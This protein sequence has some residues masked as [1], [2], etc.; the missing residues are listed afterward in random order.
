MDSHLA[1]L[2][3]ELTGVTGLTVPQVL[4]AFIVLCSLLLYILAANLAWHYRIAPTTRISRGINRLTRS[5][6]ILMLYELVRLAYYL[7]LPFGALLFGLV[8]L[9][10][11]GLT[12]IDWADGLRWAIVLVLAAWSLLM[13][14]WVPYLRAT[15][16]LTRGSGVELSSG[17]EPFT[18]RRIHAG[19]S[20]TK[21]G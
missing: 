3:Q 12:L 10:A 15:A 18:V 9:R 2:V 13:F 1:Q 19:S 7:V 8:N 11:L 5:P 4:A 6:V 17:G 16:N 21:S 20:C 14:V